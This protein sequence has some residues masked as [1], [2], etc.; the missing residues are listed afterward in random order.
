MKI[1]TREVLTTHREIYQLELNESYV[2]SVNEF[3]QR[4]CTEVLPPIT[5]EDIVTCINYKDGD[6]FLDHEY[7][8]KYWDGGT[9]K[10]VLKSMINDTVNE[11]IWN[12]EYDDEYVETGEIYDYVEE[13]QDEN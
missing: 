4:I 3:L 5:A 1:I 13:V 7:T 9:Y 8:W 12:C 11:D 6:L 2:K 10:A